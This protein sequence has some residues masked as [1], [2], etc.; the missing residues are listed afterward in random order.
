MPPYLLLDRG[1]LSV[2]DV[3]PFQ[4]QVAHSIAN[5]RRTSDHD[6]GQKAKAR[7]IRK[8]G[9]SLNQIDVSDKLV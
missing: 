7:A 4:Y 9:D 5:H 2:R 1:T 6:I 8:E 3:Q